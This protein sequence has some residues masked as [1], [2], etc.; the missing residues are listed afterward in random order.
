MGVSGLGLET[1]ASN[2]WLPVAPV[3]RV[4]EAPYVQAQVNLLKSLQG[5]LLVCYLAEMC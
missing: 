1:S 5:V 4:Q 3:C 2:R